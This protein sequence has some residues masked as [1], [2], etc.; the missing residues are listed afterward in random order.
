MNFS[1]LI[2]SLSLKHIII[3][4]YLL[5]VL[6]VNLIVDLVLFVF[7][8]KPEQMLSVKSLVR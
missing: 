1:H 8:I 6:S 5:R 7:Q 3:C 4:A 2:V